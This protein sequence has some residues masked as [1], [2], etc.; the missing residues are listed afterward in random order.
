[1]LRSLTTLTLSLALWASCTAE[2]KAQLIITHVNVIP[3]TDANLIL[4]DRDV[5]IRNGRINATRDSA[6]NS[7]TSHE[8]V[9]G[10]GKWLIPGLTH[11][12]MHVLDLAYTGVSTSD[13]YLPY[14]ANGVLQVVNLQAQPKGIEERKELSIGKA[15]GPQLMVARMIDGSPPIWPD[16]IV[17]TTPEEGRAAVRRIQA[18][19][20]DL[21]KVYTQLNLETFTAIIAERACGISRWLGICRCAIGR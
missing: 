18:E 9:D 15:I 19:G 17:A 10:R 16:S 4:P 6:P 8:T 3:M 2:T 12:H 13:V 21:V 20:Y 11:G 5:V 14:L 7:T 1:L